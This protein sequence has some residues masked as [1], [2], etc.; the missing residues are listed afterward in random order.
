M[1]L[2]LS[3]LLRDPAIAGFVAARWR[4]AEDTAF[5]IDLDDDRVG[6]ADRQWWQQVIVSPPGVKLMQTPGGRHDNASWAERV[7]PALT[8]LFARDVDDT[9]RCERSHT[10]KRTGRVIQVP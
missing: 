4:A 5:A 9:R 2:A 3:P 1:V 10:D 8:A 7:I 6:D